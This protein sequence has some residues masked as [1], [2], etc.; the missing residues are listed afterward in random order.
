MAGNNTNN[1]TDQHKGMTVPKLVVRPSSMLRNLTLADI[2]QCINCD[3]CLGKY[4]KCS[5]KQ[6]PK[7]EQ[8]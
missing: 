2:V 1:Q 6:D 4:N 7:T 8:R 5:N 3:L